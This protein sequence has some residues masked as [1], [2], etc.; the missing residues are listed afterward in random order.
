MAIDNPLQDPSF[1]SFPLSVLQSGTDSS[2]NPVRVLAT[3]KRVDHVRQQIEQVL[4]TDPGERVF[5][6]DFGAGVSALVFEPGNPALQA[7]A[8]KR[9]RAALTDALQGEIDPRTL[10]IQATASGVD[11]LV[12]QISYTLATISQ[13][14]AHEFTIGA[15][16]G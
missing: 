2:G 1:L 5:F 11:Q 9:L 7:L 3:S 14:E 6:P 13:S 4:F 12:I 8:V 10:D 15:G 16:G